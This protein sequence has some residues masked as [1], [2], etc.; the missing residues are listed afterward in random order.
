MVVPDDQPAPTRT[1]EHYRQ[2]RQQLK[3][4]VRKKPHA[5]STKN[6]I[7]G[8]KLRWKKYDVSMSYTLWAR[9]LTNMQIQCTDGRKPVIFPPALHRRGHYDFPEVDTRRVPCAETEF[10]S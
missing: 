7:K 10:P 3:N 8:I 6:N 2:H 9:V 5:I 1:A 4:G